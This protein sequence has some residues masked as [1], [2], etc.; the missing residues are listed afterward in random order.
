MQCEE[1][2]RPLWKAGEVVPAGRYVRV[3]EQSH[4]SLKVAGIYKE[5]Q[6]GRGEADVY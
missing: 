4:T 1:C 3:D 2:Q 6:P 5:G